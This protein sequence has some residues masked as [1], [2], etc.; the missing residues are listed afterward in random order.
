MAGDTHVGVIV[1]DADNLFCEG[2]SA[3]GGVVSRLVVVRGIIGIR[4]LGR[5]SLS[6]S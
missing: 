6:R 5:L 3:V 2:C 4:S 1:R